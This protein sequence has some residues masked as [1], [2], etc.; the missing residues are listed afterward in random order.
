MILC[1]P[2]ILW[3]ALYNGLEKFIT[4]SCQIL[5]SKAESYILS[6]FFFPGFIAEYWQRGS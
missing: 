1:N 2:L 4:I 5:N 6:D 3:F